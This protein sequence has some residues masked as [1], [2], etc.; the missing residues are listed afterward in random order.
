M[1][2]DD[3]GGGKQNGLHGERDSKMKDIYIYIYDE[4]KTVEFMLVRDGC[5]SVCVNPATSLQPG[6]L[7]LAFPHE[8]SDSCPS[9]SRLHILNVHISHFI[10]QSL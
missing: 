6:V 7:L 8:E 3:V 2:R 1:G 9:E 5:R 10:L 4:P